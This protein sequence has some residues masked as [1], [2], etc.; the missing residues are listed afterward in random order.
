MRSIDGDIYSDLD[1]PLTQFSR[2]RHIWSQISRKGTK[3]L[4]ISNRKP[5]L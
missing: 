5:Y 2:S 4:W 1:G 3:F